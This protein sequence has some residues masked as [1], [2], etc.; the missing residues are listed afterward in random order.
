[1]TP[2]F[3]RVLRRDYRKKPSRPYLLYA[4]GLLALCFLLG[5]VR[6]CL[7]ARYQSLLSRDEA[8]I[9]EVVKA[10][11]EKVRELTNEL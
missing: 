4:V 8:R 7:L 3:E 6:D 10:C 9:A 1:M 5:A 11:E 2:S